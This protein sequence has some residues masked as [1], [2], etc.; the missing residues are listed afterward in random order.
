MTKVVFDFDEKPRGRTMLE[1]AFAAC[2]AGAV[3]LPV[4]LFCPHRGLKMS[5]LGRRRRYTWLPAHQPVRVGGRRL[6]RT[7]RVR[8]MITRKRGLWQ[9]EIREL[10]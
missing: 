5:G 6:L 10:T 4:T 2:N 9:C 1:A 3:E 7:T 8:A